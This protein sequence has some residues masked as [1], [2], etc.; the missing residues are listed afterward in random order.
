MVWSKWPYRISIASTVVAV[1]LVGAYGLLADRST[2]GAQW[3]FL[4]AFIPAALT[5]WCA[6]RKMRVMRAETEI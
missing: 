1:A 3:A 2:E 6:I 5:A 4:I